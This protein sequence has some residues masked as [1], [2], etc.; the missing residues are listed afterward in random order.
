ML[1][2]MLHGVTCV[3]EGVVGCCPVLL[4]ELSGVTCVVEG[5]VGCYLYC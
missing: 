3:V 5:V 1:L 4:G 2:K